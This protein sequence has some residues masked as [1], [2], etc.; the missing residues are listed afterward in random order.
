MNIE[1]IVNK[2]VNQ[3]LNDSTIRQL[4]NEL[5]SSQSKNNISLIP[6]EAQFVADLAVIITKFAVKNATVATINS[7]SEINNSR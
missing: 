7:I 4:L 3:T 1:A 6:G 2:N 5:S